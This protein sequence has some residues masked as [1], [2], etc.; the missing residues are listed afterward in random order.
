MAIRGLNSTEILLT[1]GGSVDT[2]SSS[3]PVVTSETSN[4]I[5]VVLNYPLP[6]LE[7]K[8]LSVNRASV[9]FSRSTLTPLLS[10]IFPAEGGGQVNNA[11][12]VM[13]PL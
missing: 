13:S 10:S 12:I 9:G 6:D 4:Y 5:N 3:L 1:Q 8:I 2:K 11:Y 7:I